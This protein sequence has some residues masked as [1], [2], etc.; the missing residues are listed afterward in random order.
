MDWKEALAMRSP[1]FISLARSIVFSALFLGLIAAAVGGIQPAIASWALLF[2]I[3]LVVIMNVIIQHSTFLSIVLANFVGLYACSFTFF[4]EEQFSG[5]SAIDIQIAFALPLVAFTLGIYVQRRRIE[6]LIQH[7]QTHISTDLS[8]STFW[9]LPMAAIG[10]S[11]AF[12][13]PG[14]LAPDEVGW[15]L[16]GYM[17]VIALIA[18]ATA[19][20]IAVFVLDLGLLFKDFSTNAAHLI[21]PTFAFFT[22]YSMLAIAYGSL[23]TIIDRHSAQPNFQ[24]AGS[25]HPLTFAEGIYF[26]V[27]TL[28]SVGYGDIAAQTTAV[29]LLVVS[30]IIAGVL[31]FLFG[32]QAILAT[33]LQRRA[34]KSDT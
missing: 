15:L 32:V 29:R 20:D 1:E 25:P 26:S 30:E 10:V 6:H 3:A 31:L 8:R 28:S 12:L 2:V 22:W 5:A 9:L 4:V 17:A 11:T 14:G 23:Y 16:M 21:K 19:R 27:V 33:A 24:M 18:A 34:P 7:R 13:K